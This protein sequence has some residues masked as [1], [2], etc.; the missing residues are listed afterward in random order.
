MWHI[1]DDS[2][3]YKAEG[4]LTVIQCTPLYNPKSCQWL[5]VLYSGDPPPLR[6]ALSALLLFHHGTVYF[7]SSILSNLPSSPSLHHVL[8]LVSFPFSVS[9]D[10]SLSLPISLSFSV[11]PSS[12]ISVMHFLS[13]SFSVSLSLHHCLSSFCS[14][15]SSVDLLEA[16]QTL[17]TSCG[18]PP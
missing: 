2:F 18:T 14:L 16:E 6:S 10:S 17:F 13:L 9:T 5:T 8:N 12:F 7:S 11:C 4:P 3:C 15:P 1:R